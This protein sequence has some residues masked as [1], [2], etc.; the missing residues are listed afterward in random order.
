MTST[1][2][3]AGVE[4]GCTLPPG[5][6]PQA[7]W[8]EPPPPPSSASPGPLADQFSSSRE[9]GYTSGLE[10]SVKTGSS[11]WDSTDSPPTS[12]GTG[13]G[14]RALSPPASRAEHRPARSWL[15]SPK[16]VEHLDL[17]PHQQQP[18]AAPRRSRLQLAKSEGNLR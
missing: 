16:S 6:S 1:G 12:F 15:A 13:R 9:S 3:G 7:I 10:V 2:V 11:P 5:Y 18:V 8:A 14:R 4:V 17:L